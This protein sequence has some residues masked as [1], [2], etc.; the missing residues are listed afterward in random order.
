MLRF[1][2]PI[3]C[4]GIPVDAFFPEWQTEGAIPQTFLAKKVCGNCLARE[5]CLEYA[6]NNHVL[7]IWGGTTENERR[8]LRK[9]LNIIAVPVLPPVGATV[10]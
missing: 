2:N 8:K 6:L 4:D 9:K 10:L 1:K 3:N 7:G 5:E